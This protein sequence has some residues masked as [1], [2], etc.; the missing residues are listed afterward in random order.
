MEEEQAMNFLDLMNQATDLVAHITL[1]KTRARFL[2]AMRLVT[3]QAQITTI[4]VEVGLVPVE[5]AQ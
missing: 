2:I 4:L 5:E 3:C 1:A